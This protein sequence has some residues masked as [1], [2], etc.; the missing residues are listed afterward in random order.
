MGAMDLGGDGLPLEVRH[1]PAEVVAL[2]ILVN[3]FLTMV[4]SV[5]V[6]IM[7]W[8]MAPLTG[9]L[10]WWKRK[11]GLLFS[12]HFTSFDEERFAT[13]KEGE[14]GEFPSLSARASENITLSVVVLAY[15]EESRLAVFLDD[16][17]AYLQK[18]QITKPGFG[19]EII[20]VDNASRDFTASSTARFVH[21]YGSNIVRTLRLRH[22]HEDGAA[23]RKGVLRTRGEFIL[24]TRAE[25]HVALGELDRLESAMTTMQNDGI[26]L[27]SRAHM[28][29]DLHSPA[30]RS[31]SIAEE[32]HSDVKGG[33]RNSSGPSSS[34]LYRK[35][36]N[37]QSPSLTREVAWRIFQ[38]VFQMS[39]ARDIYD[40]VCPFQLYS[41]HAAQRVFMKEHIDTMASVC[42]RL[43]L[44]QRY[45]IP[46][47][48]RAVHWTS[49]HDCIP[50]ARESVDM[51]RDTLVMVT[52]RKLNLW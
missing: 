50:S 21:K 10:L 4:L 46:V 24:V 33:N 19:F 39:C 7:W 22:R 6:I 28:Q 47:I 13:E 23:I 52:M 5:N 25:G 42:E 43:F 8:C 16:S 44:A 3:V 9:S 12:R 2:Q 14:Y 31:L 15:N 20:V 36:Q 27:G 29:L 38:V 45:G 30:K 18:R 49:L 26:V 34:A 35:A 1:G 51:A 41:R 11:I 17:M 32:D 40:P 37:A 48:E